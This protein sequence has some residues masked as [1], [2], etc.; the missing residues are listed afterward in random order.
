VLLPSPLCSSLPTD[1]KKYIQA[2]KD[3][4]EAEEV[5]RQVVEAAKDME[6]V[7]RKNAARQ[8]VLEMVA[9]AHANVVQQSRDDEDDDF[10]V[11]ML[12]RVTNVFSGE[13]PVEPAD[14]LTTQAQEGVQDGEEESMLDAFTRRVSTMLEPT[15]AENESSASAGTGVAGA[16][17]SGAVEVALPGAADGG[18]VEVHDHTAENGQ[19]AVVHQEGQ[20][21]HIGGAEESEGNEAANPGPTAEVAQADGT[22]DFF[23]LRKLSTMM[24]IDPGIDA[25]NGMEK[26]GSRSARTPTPDSE[27]DE[28]PP[29][30]PG[31]VF[32]LGAVKRKDEDSFFSLRKLSTIMTSP[33]ET[34]NGK[35][36]DSRAGL[37]DKEEGDDDY[38][39]DEEEEGHE[40]NSYEVPAADEGAP[41]G[42]PQS[43]TAAPLLP[44]QPQ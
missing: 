5:H 37:S 18:A 25:P 4:D 42:D 22:A 44:P 20:D 23:G 32:N 6:E 29:A 3:L 14:I 12:R 16:A 8:Y 19:A 39:D 11:S 38:D 10:A 43:I 34:L 35:T 21:S 33:M 9:Q 40:E 31:V 36:V 41:H 30:S 24:G 2:I 7:E 15:D 28:H 13:S 27:E 26:P 17:E 1:L